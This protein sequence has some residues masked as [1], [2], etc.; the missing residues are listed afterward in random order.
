[1][2]RRAPSAGGELYGCEPAA[3]LGGPPG[4]LWGTR[5]PDW[6]IMAEPKSD[7]GWDAPEGRSGAGTSFRLLF[8][9]LKQI[10]VN[11]SRSPAPPG[12]HSVP[13]A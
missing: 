1:M 8:C 6:D 11:L 7:L 3:R 4:P 12:A 10:R 5:C 9:P 13:Q 2:H